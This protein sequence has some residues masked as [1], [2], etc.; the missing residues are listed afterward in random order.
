MQAIC[1]LF[2]LFSAP[3]MAAE[4]TPEDPYRYLEDAADPRT[5]A[6]FREQGAAARAALDAIPGRAEMLARIRALSEGETT[7]TRLVATPSRAFYLKLRPREPAAV[8]CVR[9]GLAGAE[10]V[11]VDPRR[12]ES[13][14]QRAAIDWFVPSPDG[15]HVAFGVSTGGSEDSTLRVLAVE[16]ARL[17]P[18]EIDRTRFNSQLAWHP[19]SQSFYY[20]RI[21]ESDSAARRY[22]NIRMYRHVLGRDTAR[23]E[24]VFAPGAGGAR[25]VPVSVRP[26]IHVP[27]ESRYAY[28]IARDGVRREI[29]VHV[30]LQRDLATG[31]PRWHKIAG[32]EDEVLAIEGW[33]DELYVLSRRGAPRHRLLRAKGGDASLA[34]ARVVVPQGESVIQGFGI[35]RDALYL[36]T[37]VGGVDRLERVAIGLLG[38]KAPQYVRTPFDNGISQLVTHPRIPGA[39]IRIQGWI[40][41]PAVLQVEAGSGNVRVTAIQPPALADF[42]EMD[43]VRLYAPGHDGTRIPVTL[44][45]RKSTRLDG[46]NPTLVTAHGSHG[47]T[48]EPRFEPAN[49]AWLERGGVLA[50]AHVRGGGEFGEEWHEG[51]RGAA[52]ANTILDAIA[53]AEFLVTYGFTHPRRLAIH[54]TQ[55]G[56]IPAAGALVRRPDLFAAVVARSPLTDMLRFERSADGPAN[57]P[58]FGTSA[59]AEGLAALRVMSSYHLVKDATAYPAVLLT[60]GMN[61]PRVDAWQPGKM[62]ARLQAASS[63]GKPVLLRVEFEGGHGRAFTRQQ[64]EE[65]L[66]DVFSF[67]LWQMG[68]P[69]FLPTPPPPPVQP[70]PPSADVAPAP[71]GAQAT[72]TETTQPPLPAPPP[73]QPSK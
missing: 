22:A 72:P 43:E 54:G 5:Q 53:A 17:L 46:R 40:E 56:G 35:A 47:I 62:A 16:G 55:A 69:Q 11:L 50:V 60:T 63:S 27:L 68:E 73:A 24:I 65:E 29:A 1:L 25:D 51:G 20:A 38:A 14:S 4:A 19:D 39:L 9:E 12:F 36:K 42:S 61:D 58:E 41:P 57:A 45:Y 7:V 21:P 30:T 70:S 71:A 66:A 49:L 48:L 34:T 64:R 13:G 10:R 3:A 6:F 15:R 2:V 8:L 32:H 18:L 37:M 44:V 23:D 26:S 59:T 33:R 31:R 52:K 28:A 67:L